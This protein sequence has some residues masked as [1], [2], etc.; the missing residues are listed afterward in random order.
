MTLGGDPLRASSVL[1]NLSLGPLARTFLPIGP[2]LVSVTPKKCM[3]HFAA[4]IG[5]ALLAKAPVIC[6]ARLADPSSHRGAIF[7]P[8][9]NTCPSMGRITRI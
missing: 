7:H 4:A 1:M 2:S 5:D 9:P 6:D 8:G 3:W